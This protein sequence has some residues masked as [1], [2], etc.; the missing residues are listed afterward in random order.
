MLSV[1]ST[2]YD[3]GNSLECLET[4]I[5]VG[6][7]NIIEEQE[8]KPLLPPNEF[9]A[10][11]VKTEL[12]AVSDVMIII[13]VSD[14]MR[15]YVEFAM[16]GVKLLVGNLLG[17]G[18]GNEIKR[19]KP[20]VFKW[21]EYFDSRE[22]I[23]NFGGKSNYVLMMNCLK[24]TLEHSR[25][26]F[27]I[28][29]IAAGNDNVNKPEQIFN[30]LEQ[31]RAVIDKQHVDIHCIGVGDEHDVIILDNFARMATG[32][33]TY[34]VA[35][36]GQN[37][38][39]KIAGLSA[40][41]N[42]PT[43][44]IN[45]RLNG[46]LY[47]AFANYET[48][49]DDYTVTSRIFGKISNKESFDTSGDPLRSKESV[50]MLLAN[51]EYQQTL[52]FTPSDLCVGIDK[53]V[54]S[55]IVPGS[56]IVK[57]YGI[58]LQLD[59]ICACLKYEMFESVLKAF[60]NELEVHGLA[61]KKLLGDVRV[62]I[63]D[64]GFGELEFL[65]SLLTYHNMLSEQ[66]SRGLTN[67]HEYGE[68]MKGTIDIKLSDYSRLVAIGFS[69]GIND[70][71]EKYSKR[72]FI[73][74]RADINLHKQ[75]KLIASPHLITEDMFM[76]RK[77]FPAIVEGDDS[78]YTMIADPQNMSE[79]I[80]LQLVAGYNG[81]LSDLPLDIALPK[82]N[83]IAAINDTVKTG[84]LHDMFKNNIDWLLGA[85]RYVNCNE[86]SLHDVYQ[87]AAKLTFTRSLTKE[88]AT[89]PAIKFCEQLITQIG[90]N[91]RHY[92]GKL[93]E[94]K[95]Y[96]SKLTSKNLEL[97][98]Q[99]V[100][101]DELKK[102]GI[103]H[104]KPQGKRSANIN[105]TNN[106]ASNTKINIP[107][108]EMQT[109]VLNFIGF[110]NS[111]C[112]PLANINTHTD[113]DAYYVEWFRSSI[114]DRL[115]V[116]AELYPDII[117]FDSSIDPFQ[118]IIPGAQAL[119]RS[120]IVVNIIKQYINNEKKKILG[121]IDKA[122]RDEKIK[123][124][125]ATDRVYSAAGLLRGAFLGV[126]LSKYLGTLCEAAHGSRLGK[127]PKVPLLAEKLYMIITGRLVLKTGT[128]EVISSPTTE[129]TKS[130][131]LVEDIPLHCHQRRF[132]SQDTFNACSGFS[133]KMTRDQ[134]VKHMNR[135]AATFCVDSP[136]ATW[137]LGHKKKRLVK[138][139]IG[140]LVNTEYV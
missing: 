97:Q 90:V 15:E 93:D 118:T 25:G 29:L 89:T 123:A 81:N 132:T 46:K 56:L 58:K 17:V 24:E 20:V 69:C 131:I 106:S 101:I 134:K 136:I 35:S 119:L 100:I 16:D 113:F 67:V 88:M 19:I 80:A 65:N 107:P 114:S 135:Y 127:N 99:S 52:D 6:K 79:E 7:Q 49:N 139:M 87:L 111:K 72:D 120:S 54:L 62:Y 74:Y 12:M 61:I 60:R 109:Y 122:D 124:F 73:Q 42:T 77:K 84:K 117:T 45:Y 112:S 1:K 37:I 32:Q 115:K 47:R 22:N 30:E 34:Q 95:T 75:L 98:A 137:K 11:N 110:I 51:G 38:T 23:N 33:C 86:I 83:V 2:V 3:A 125:V 26:K 9:S 128:G 53:N 13:D 76:K 103:K 43:V 102:A 91:E 59:S 71:E 116:F 94:V 78:L 41:L 28:V 14:F 108:S 5:T 126:N 130:I 82:E 138:A 50:E 18:S 68:D 63:S 85:V 140:D 4:I 36:V 55:N 21:N 44:R 133:E 105:P 121:E 70:M 104:I 8:E 64:V 40:R 27:A 31:L 57:M 10:S 92:S 66:Y 48:T 129:H 39:D 96:R